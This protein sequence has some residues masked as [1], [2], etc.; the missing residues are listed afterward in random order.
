MNLAH[1]VDLRVENVLGMHLRG[2]LAIDDTLALA[3]VIAVIAISSI[4]LVLFTFCL[5]A[6][7]SELDHLRIR[8]HP[9]VRC[10]LSFHCL[11]G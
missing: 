11:W 10:L 3:L 6:A 4:S 1:Q 5:L 8:L 2:R 9:D 7:L